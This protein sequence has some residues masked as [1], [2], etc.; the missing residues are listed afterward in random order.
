L[1]QALSQAW[2]AMHLSGNVFSTF[3]WP[4]LHWIYSSG[5]NKIAAALSQL[6]SYGEGAS[7]DE[8][9]RIKLSET[10]IPIPEKIVFEAS[11]GC[12]MMSKLQDYMPCHKKVFSG[13][14]LV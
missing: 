3:I 1:E 6:Q 11:H 5:Q 4:D 13:C 2:Q 9:F 10:Q 14:I 7:E 12:Q 8:S